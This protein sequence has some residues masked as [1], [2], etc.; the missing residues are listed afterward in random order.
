MNGTMKGATWLKLGLLLLFLVGLGWVL[1]ALGIDVTQVN[2][3]RIRE[4]VLGFGIW[5]PVVYLLAY[6][7]PIVPLPA[8]VMTI[9]GGLAFGPLWGS[10]AALSGATI[11]AS[12]QFL[13]ARM[14]GRGVVEKLLKGKAASLDQKIGEHVF[15]AVLLIRLIPS[16][17]FDMLNYGL[18]FS[19]VRF[20]SYVLA[21]FLGMIPGT[22]AYVYLGYSLTDPKHLW[23]LG[24][25]ILLI[26]GLMLGQRA[27]KKSRHTQHPV[28]KTAHE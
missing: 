11:R 3:E 10:A 5:A 27:W 24:L 9:T 19:K 16:F 2:P 15:K 23:K 4:F 28:T 25:A 26:V 18:G 14:L 21:S 13:V 20:R 1:K 17:P 12:T 22:F 8:S 6:G 7:Q